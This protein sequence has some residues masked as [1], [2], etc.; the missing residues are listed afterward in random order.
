VSRPRRGFLEGSPRLHY[1]E[2][3]PGGEQTLILVHG[4]SANVWWWEPLAALMPPRF[5]ILALDQRGHGDSD[6]VRPPAYSPADYAH[7]LA[8]FVEACGGGQPVVVGHSMGGLSVLAFADRYP[9]RARAAVAID[10]AVTS[11]RG[12]DRFL[13]RLRALPTVSYPDLETARAR[14]RLMPSEGA[15]AEEV[16]AAIAEKSLS[17]T[18]QGRFTLK[19]DRESFFGSD[20]IDA[21]SVVRGVRIPLL[22]VRGELSRIMTAEGAQRAL[23]ANS[24]ARLEVIAGAHHHLPLER[25]DALAGMIA[26]FVEG[27]GS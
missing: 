8:R 15:I 7:D 26:R 20:G 4:N 25:P 2:W 18:E 27:L 22:L 16:V 23:E 11:S 24:R 21:L 12:R 9:N 13:R 6:W 14:F 1:L 19:F 10:V 3:H 17:R 5:R